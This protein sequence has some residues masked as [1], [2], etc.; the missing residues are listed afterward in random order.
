MRKPYWSWGEMRL[1]GGLVWTFLVVS[2]FGRPRELVGQALPELTRAEAFGIQMQAL[3][4]MLDTIDIRRTDEEL[5]RLWL[6]PRASEG[7][8]S[9]VV[10]SPNEVDQLR[11]LAPTLRHTLGSREELFVCPEGRSVFMP[12]SGCPIKEDGAIV[13]VTDPRSAESFVAAH[14]AR[15]LPTLGAEVI[16]SGSVTQTSA[17]GERTNLTGI[18]MGFRKQADEWVF[19]GILAWVLS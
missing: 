6:L 16:V 13:N 5:P 8:D 2:A 18:T 9:G 14:R 15:G 10:F 1:I 19:V 4:I 12:L 11:E 3:Q 7:L 17:D